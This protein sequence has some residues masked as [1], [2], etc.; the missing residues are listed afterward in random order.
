MKNKYVILI[1]VDGTLVESG[2]REV[3]KMVIDS[4]KYAKEKGN[5]LA[6][7]TGRSVNTSLMVK[8][9][10]YFDY[11]ACLMGSVIY[12]IKENKVIYE[13]K[14][15]MDNQ[16]IKPLI[17]YF[18]NS[19]KEWTY[20]DDKEDKST[21]DI[22]KLENR[23]N[24]KIVSKEEVFEDIKNDKI[25]QLLA[26]KE[27]IDD[28]IKNKFADLDFVFMPGDYYD[29]LKKG[30]SK[31]NVV[32]YFKAK[33]PEYKIVAIGDSNNDIPM[34]KTADI[35]VAMGNAKSNVKNLCKYQTKTLTEDGVSY[36]IREL[37][38]I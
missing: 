37:L 26:C 3:S 28:K 33:F 20:K 38:K 34:L 29:I 27:L 36:A 9:S 18:I 19:G 21:M 13:D 30:N 32:K 24:A 23:F 31:A 14:N 1:D 25:F 11:I 12:S 17:E 35:S 15:K 7:A 6:I 5:I 8:G 2:T 22:S 16:Y 4:L 10:N